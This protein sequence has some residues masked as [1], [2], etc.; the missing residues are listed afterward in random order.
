MAISEGGAVG[1]QDVVTNIKTARELNPRESYL[2]FAQSQLPYLLDWQVE[3]MQRQSISV[4]G[5]KRVKNTID[6]V[7]H[8]LNEAT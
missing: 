5:L 7:E 8:D 1:D 6:M 4:E 3:I 2:H